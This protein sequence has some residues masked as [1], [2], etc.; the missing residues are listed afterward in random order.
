MFSSTFY[1]TPKEVI[2]K[3]LAPYVVEGRWGTNYRL[4]GLSILEPSAGKG[5]ILDFIEDV[6]T[7]RSTKLY[8]CEIEP[9][10]KY[11]L[12]EK[13]YRVLADDFLNYSG[14]YFFDLVVMNPPF[15]TATKHILKAWEIL[16]SGEIVALCNIE[17]I[18]NP[19]NKE[20]QLLKNLIE[21]F[22]C[23]E[24]IGKVFL[25][26]EAERKTSTEC[27]IVR[28]KKVADKNPLEFDFSKLNAESGE[29]E[30]NEDTLKNQVARRN[31]IH[32]MEAQYK[33]MKS[34]FVEYMKVRQ[35]L[36]FYSNSILT[37]YNYPIKMAD[38]AIEKSNS[39]AQAYNHFNDDLKQEIWKTVFS[40]TKVEKF[41]TKKV[42]KNFDSFTKSQGYMD[43]NLDN[44]DSLVEMIFENRHTIMEQAIIDVFDIMTKYHKKNRCHIEGWKTN[45][46]WKV[47]R[48]V[49]L[50]NALKFNTQDYKTY[51]SK[52]QVDYYSESDLLDIDKALCYLTGTPYEF[53]VPIN[54]ALSE[55][56]KLIGNIRPGDYFDNATESTFFN[57]KFFKKGT[58]HVEFKDRLVWELFNLTACSGKKWLPESEE[59]EF[60]NGADFNSKQTFILLSSIAG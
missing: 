20:R 14:D 59:Q 21:S 5:N 56:F 51:G 54:S 24:H 37:Q 43:F 44:I 55:R 46:K 31:I 8:A 36:N 26:N 13:G 17:T 42:R 11:I 57:I 12:Q 22:G 4:S 47:N 15:N 52:F 3:M 16:S 10:L 27:S 6:T 49:I 25:N 40:K 29:E 9:E 23:V 2:E 41:M 53:C 1:P 39:K 38:E 33:K 28:L 58:I 19:F 34:L 48:K 50:P 45:D 7:N 18:R 30:L 32:N 35:A 60:S